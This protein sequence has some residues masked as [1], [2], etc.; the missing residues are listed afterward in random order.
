[1]NS[2][3]EIKKV[4][5]AT[6]RHHG[7]P[8][9]GNIHPSP[10]AHI[11]AV[12]KRWLA[13]DGDVSKGIDGYR[14]DV[15]DQIGM[16]F[17]REW[18]GYVKSIN[19]E[20]YLVGEIWWEEWPGKLMDPAPYTQGDIFDAV[21]FYQ[22]Y[23]PARYFF[24]KTNF[25]ID[26][27]QLVD[28]LNFE[29]NRLGEPFRYAMMNTAATH[30]APR[31]LTSFYNPNMYKSAAKPGDDPNYKTGIPDK[32]TYQ[33]TKLYL[34]HHF[35]NIGAPQIWNGDEMGMTGADD[36]DCRKPLWWPEFDFEPEYVNNFQP[37]EKQFEEVGFNKAWFNFYKQIIKIRKENP[38][39]SHGELG[40]LV[41]NEKH[42]SYKRFDENDEIIVLFNLD[43]EPFSFKLPAKAT[44][45]DLMSQKTFTGN[46]IEIQ[47]L[48]GKI[49]KRVN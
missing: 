19:P 32:E 41:A 18:H 40:F 7:H 25:E 21:M 47:A 33:R 24:A 30:D 1:L 23:R 11:F 35:T 8:Y 6:E 2:L 20:A 27:T 43:K 37:G 36:P 45:Q 9:E 5:I 46:H 3:P 22:I 42:F 10:K 48:D 26:A 31:L 34:M 29:W 16:K 44:Y 17:W 14:L 28:S 15:A 4:D 12:T 13:P 38:V 39:L 49:L